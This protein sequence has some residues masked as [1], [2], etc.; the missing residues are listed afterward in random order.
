V[1]AHAD[2]SIVKVRL[3]YLRNWRGLN[4]FVALIQYR[5]CFLV[6]AIANFSEARPHALLDGRMLEMTQYLKLNARD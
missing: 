5:C 4:E 6:P 2:T 3:R 1:L